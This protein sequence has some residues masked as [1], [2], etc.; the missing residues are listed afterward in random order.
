MSMA[1][2]CKQLAD[3]FVRALMSYVAFGVE[4][5]RRAT[6]ELRQSR[7]QALA[8]DV[9]REARKIMAVKSSHRGVRHR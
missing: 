7:Y 5:D 2:P 1:E 6:Y 9:A 8:V 4:P 3:D